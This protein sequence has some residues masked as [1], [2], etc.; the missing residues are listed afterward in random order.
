MQNMTLLQT[1]V[2]AILQAIA[3]VIFIFIVVPLTTFA[4]RK[5]L[6]YLQDRLGATRIAGS[7]N[8]LTGYLNRG[9]WKMGKV[10]MLSSSCW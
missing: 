4:E 1:C 9:M 6:G 7:R 5:V 2:M 8:G 3:V 10:P